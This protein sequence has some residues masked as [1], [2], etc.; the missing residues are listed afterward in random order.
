MSVIF[1]AVLKKEDH[2]R[3]GTDSYT[4]DILV[5]ETAVHMSN[6]VSRLDKFDFIANLPESLE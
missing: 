3:E 5:D 4:N 2:M 6:L 1:K